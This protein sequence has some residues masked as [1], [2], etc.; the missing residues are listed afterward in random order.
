M[1]TGSDPK[2]PSYESVKKIVTLDEAQGLPERE[3]EVEWD[4]PSPKTNPGVAERVV[5]EWF[6][7][8]YQWLKGLVADESLVLDLCVERTIEIVQHN[9]DRGMVGIDHFPEAGGNGGM[10]A[11]RISIVATA[12]PLAVELYK[13]TLASIKEKE[14]EFGN[15]VADALKKRDAAKK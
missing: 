9:H 7:N 8:V 13:Q 15:L 6:E 4:K 11:N 2:R 1:T 10:T 5:P 3:I 12:M 14:A